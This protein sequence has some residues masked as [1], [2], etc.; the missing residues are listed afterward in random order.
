[1]QK[2]GKTSRGKQRWLCMSCQRS[3]IRKRTD[4]KEFFL[5]KEFIKWLTGNATLKEIAL[6]RKISKR[7]IIRYFKP[8][9]SHA[10]KPLMTVSSDRYVLICDGVYI[11]KRECCVLIARTKLS[12]ISWKFT[13][14]ESTQ[15]WKIFFQKLKKPYAVVC[16]GQK[17]ML[18]AIRTLWSTTRIQR[19]LAHLIRSEQTYLTKKPKTKAGKELVLLLKRLSLIWTRRQKRRWIRSYWNVFNRYASLLKE[20]SYLKRPNGTTTWWY[21]HRHLRSAYYLIKHSLAEMFVYVGHYDI[22]RTT[23]H[24]EGGINSRLKELLH[25]HRGLRIQKK[26]VLISQFLITKCH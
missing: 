8:L 23:N 3:I 11:Y 18:L 9:W 24:V 19:C 26:K 13:Q 16:D 12:V 17:G 22:P 10:H 5:R 25:R 20:R 21:T 7:T 2:W 1:M 6:R 15:S 14:Y 4:T